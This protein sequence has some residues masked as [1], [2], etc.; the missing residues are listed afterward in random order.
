MKASLSSQ[1]P[2]IV[3]FVLLLET[4]SIRQSVQN[5]HFQGPPTSSIQKRALDRVS[6]TNARGDRG[7]PF[8]GAAAIVIYEYPSP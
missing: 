6:K 3:K 8:R 2:L 7:D 5:G 4:L 1:S